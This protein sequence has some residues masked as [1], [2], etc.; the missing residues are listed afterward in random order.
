LLEFLREK[1]TAYLDEMV[2]FLF[3]KY[4]HVMAERTVF[5]YLYRAQ[6]SRKVASK[7]AKN[8][9]ELLRHFF[10]LSTRGWDPI[11]IVALDESAANERTADRTSAWAPLVSAAIAP[12]F[13]N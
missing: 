11:Q 8:R 3:D 12:Y 2:E 10:Y 1:P 13:G 7:H 4:N 5:D 6:W 9:S